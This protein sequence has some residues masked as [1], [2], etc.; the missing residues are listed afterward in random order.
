[1]S[2]ETKA[3]LDPD[4]PAEEMR[5]H[6]GELSANEVLVARAA[7]RW[8]NS[9]RVFQKSFPDNIRDAIAIRNRSNSAAAVYFEKYN[10]YPDETIRTYITAQAVEIERLRGERQWRPIESAPCDRLIEVFAP[11]CNADIVPECRGPFFG[12][13]IVIAKYDDS[14]GF[15]VSE[16]HSATHWREHN[17]PAGEPCKTCKGTGFTVE[18]IDDRHGNQEIYCLTCYG[19]GK[20]K[21]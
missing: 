18:Y 14:A 19:T 1:M 4:M 12:P 6:M 8:A 9:I 5:L 15:F 20:D 7:I 2:Q 21:P 16:S 11:D 10:E 3:P 13:K 17:P